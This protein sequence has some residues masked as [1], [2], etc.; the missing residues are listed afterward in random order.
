MDVYKVVV[1][2]NDAISK[3]TF[4]LQVCSTR[5]FVCADQSQALKHSM[6]QLISQAF[7]GICD[8]TIEEKYHQ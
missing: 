2:G 7:I 5:K 6:P 3:T 8:P 1:L 4:A